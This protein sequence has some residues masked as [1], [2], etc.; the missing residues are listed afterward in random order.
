MGRLGGKESSI[1]P[2]SEATASQP[3][4]AGGG[5]ICPGGQT[6]TLC[7]RHLHPSVPLPVLGGTLLWPGGFV[8][9]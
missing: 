7:R 8:R 1:Q 3:V 5:V 6:A 4:P 9:Q 2:C